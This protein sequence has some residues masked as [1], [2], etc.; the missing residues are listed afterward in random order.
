MSIKPVQL[1]AIGQ[2]GVTVHDL[3]RATEFYRD[4]LGMNFIFQVPGM[5]SFFDCGGTRL[6]LGIPT[7][8]KY[9]H[10]SSTIYYRVDDIQQTFAALQAQGV[11]FT[12]NPHSVGQMG[13]IDIWM[14]FFE[15]VDK[16][17]LAIMSEVRINE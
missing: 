6:M 17:T 14:A 15:D 3:D 5:M 16:N 1:S 12:H 13:Q 10:P 11:E 9:D 4:T 2:I 8:A 7:S